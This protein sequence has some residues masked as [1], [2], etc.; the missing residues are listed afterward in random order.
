MSREAMKQALEALE[1]Y[2]GYMEPLTTVF[3]GPRVPAEQSTTGKVEKAITA[4]RQALEQPDD[5]IDW[6]DQYEKQKRRAE[7]WV[8]KYEKDIGPVEMAVP[9]QQSEAL[10]LADALEQ[11]TRGYEPVTDAAR[12]LRRLYAENQRLKAQPADEPVFWRYALVVEGQEVNE[13][14]TTV[15]WDTRFEPFGRRGIDH[16]GEVTKQPLYTR[17]Q[18]A[19]QPPKFPTMLRKMWTGAE[20]QAWINDHWS[21]PAAQEQQLNALKNEAWNSGVC[22]VCNSKDEPP[23]DFINALKFD[24]AKRDATAWVG[25]TDEEVDYI[26]DEHATLQG[27]IRAIEAK[28]KEKNS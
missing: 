1:S 21:G 6:K 12:E 5:E 16:G 9:M 26:A 17:P 25:L 22:P 20:V 10:K 8:A 23:A 13:A 2:H 19:A 18:P 14:F 28:L 11:D 24:V 7:M 27:A 3:G 15:N 4:L